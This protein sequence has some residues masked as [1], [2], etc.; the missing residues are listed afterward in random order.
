[1]GDIGL[2]SNEERVCVQKEKSHITEEEIFRL[3]LVALLRNE[4]FCESK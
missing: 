4:L 2:C 3:L 1:M